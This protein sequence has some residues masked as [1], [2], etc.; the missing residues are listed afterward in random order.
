MCWNRERIM[1]GG[2]GS[3]ATFCDGVLAAGDNVIME[4]VLEGAFDIVHSEEAREVRF[5]FAE[6][7]FW[8]TVAIE[9]IAAKAVLPSLNGGIAGRHQARLR[10]RLDSPRPAVAK[11]KLWQQV[12]GREIRSAVVRGN[13]HQDVGRRGLGIFDKYIEVAVVVEDARVE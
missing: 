11:P 2:F 10:G 9:P 12:Q 6:A 8:R 3:C 4:G 5:I 13:A 7:N 1:S